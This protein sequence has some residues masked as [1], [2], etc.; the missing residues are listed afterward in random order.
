M[1]GGARHRQRTYVASITSR[2]VGILA[3]TGRAGRLRD[4]Q[5]REGPARLTAPSGVTGAPAV[6]GVPAP[7]PAATR[8]NCQLDLGNP[9][10]CGALDSR[11]IGLDSAESSGGAVVSDPV[12]VRPARGHCW[13]PGQSST[14]GSLPFHGR[15]VMSNKAHL[16][17]HRKKRQASRTTG[18]LLVIVF[19]ALVALATAMAASGHAMPAGRILPLGGGRRR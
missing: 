13:V 4:R 7:R 16:R 2:R 14:I 12:G 18:L 5:G 10:D 9:G 6:A 11:T 19:V 17:P 8:M 1:C 3:R 15:N